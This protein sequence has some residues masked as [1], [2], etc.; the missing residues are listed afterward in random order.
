MD[1]GIFV[2]FPPPAPI[3][4]VTDPLGNGTTI[5]ANDAE[6]QFSSPSPCIPT[7]PQLQDCFCTELNQLEQ[8]YINYPPP[9][10]CSMC[11]PPP[12]NVYIANKLNITYGTSITDIDVLNYESNCE[13]T[14]TPS[15]P[16][17]NGPP[18]AMNCNTYPNS[19]CPE[20]AYTI[21]NYDAQVQ[22][23]QQK[24]Q[25]LDDFINNYMSAAFNG[26]D[27]YSE[28]MGVRYINGE[29][30]YT[31]YY[32]DL[33]GNLTRTVP[34]AGVDI[35]TDAQVSA[36]VIP[37]HSKITYYQYNTLNELVSET[38]PDAGYTSH[39][40]DYAGRLRFSQNANQVPL[41][42]YSYT[43]YDGVGRIIE[44]GE[45]HE[46]YPPSGTSPFW[47]GVND[48][49]FPAPPY[50]DQVTQTYYDIPFPWS[51]SG[52]QA[53]FDGG[54]QQNLEAR[55]ATTT[56]AS[57][58][59][60]TGAYD[61][62]THYSYDP[63][64][65]VANLLQDNPSLGIFLE[66]GTQEYKKMRYDY[67]LV[68]GNVNMVDYQP[69][70]PDQFIHKY[71]Y[72]ADNR[73]TNAYTSADSVI[74]DQDAKYFYYLHG[75]L[76]R[77]EIGQD[78]VQGE[79]Y[80]Y[81]LQGWLKGVNANVL[82]PV[83]DIGQDGIN[84]PGNYMPAPYTNAQPYIHMNIAQD[85]FGYTLNYFAG[86]NGLPG[87]YY[88][89]D[90]VAATAPNHF[91]KNHI[92]DNYDED[93]FNGNIKQT[94]AALS[95][96]TNTALPL[97]DIHYQ[98]D[99]LNRLLQS[100]PYINAVSTTDYTSSAPTN[101]SALLADFATAYTYD[102]DGNI[103]N[104]SRN[105]A[106]VG[107]TNNLDNLTYSYPANTPTPT[108]NLL[109][110]VQDNPPAGGQLAPCGDI[111]PG[112]AAGNYSY[113]MIGQLISDGSDAQIQN[114][115]W[116]IYGK[117]LSVTRIPTSILSDLQ[118]SYDP[119]GNR[120]CKIEIPKDVS[121]NPL[122]QDH[123][124]YT[125]YVRDASGN[126]M[127]IYNRTFSSPAIPPLHYLPSEQ[128]TLAENPIYGS[129]RI[130]DANRNTYV[131]TMSY[132]FGGYNNDGTII[133]SGTYIGKVYNSMSTA[134][135]SQI[136]QGPNYQ[137]QT[138]N[139]TYELNDHLGDVLMT[140]SDRKLPIVSATNP[141]NVDHYVADVLSYNTYYPFG[142]EMKGQ[143]NTLYLNGASGT[144]YRFAY[145]G[146]E[147]DHE[148]KG[149]DNSYT[150]EFREFDPRLGRWFT[151][152][153]RT[154]EL[155]W[156]SPYLS[157]G[158]NPIMLNDINGDVWKTDADEKK[159][160]K[161]DNIA[162]TLMD[163]YQNQLDKLDPKSANY[164]SDKA[165]L[166]FK[167]NEL[168][169]AKDELQAMGNDKSM[170]FQFKDTKESGSDNTS[171]KY[172][173]GYTFPD[174]TTDRLPEVTMT[175]F[176]DPDD[177][178]GN[179]GSQ[180]HEAKHAYQMLTGDLKNTYDGADKIDEVTSEVQAKQREYAIMGGT[181]GFM[182]GEGYLAITEANWVKQVM[183]N[184]GIEEGGKIP[185][186]YKTIA[187]KWLKKQKEKTP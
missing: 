133:Y 107:T 39:W 129:K 1:Y 117:V 67:D 163:K 58:G 8:E 122:T 144:A 169:D 171:I 116:S 176:N 138:G 106:T 59:N 114:I 182:M 44:T 7:S 154:D 132:N 29:Y 97:M 158:N 89:I 56:Y 61:Y 53:E 177:P 62:A 130:G 168:H 164:E 186:V 16:S 152:D 109:D 134:P 81:T 162:S 18:A 32:Y 145:N 5:S 34:P 74:W 139:K 94:A 40:Y 78:K 125:Y 140:V 45:S 91:Y 14:G 70:S 80:A 37:T 11:P 156:E 15:M 118:F 84:G 9:G 111:Q 178:I 153:P 147:Q 119:M 179:I 79:D 103:L 159:A 28:N 75:P 66:N 170:I 99:Q 166:T 142:Q 110:N 172:G 85:A 167:I 12:L 187:K 124:I 76:G 155:A 54:G 180:F 105:G 46:P 38:T 10:I 102:F 43:K 174:G 104:L 68:S 121:G 112:Q 49:E 82:N 64:G 93:L 52:L 150:T 31:L 175:V 113:D 185:R 2:A 42:E 22:Y 72:D 77:E 30:Q 137:R 120:I 35:L 141:P 26:I 3:N 51:T 83:V 88:S 146:M 21:A 65:N 86:S 69:E 25:Q 184:K 160:I 108:N 136:W 165:D 4:V 6:G 115:H 92:T 149:I 151:T 19:I 95:N 161:M 17:T 135:P 27:G 55:V 96:L 100:M 181:K 47:N 173:V 101:A 50:T 98:Y 126:I 57:V 157:M 71:E 13:L 24:Q 131:S 90:P 36:R 183:A 41:I 20:D 23:N 33:A 48:P 123:W 143:L 63:H 127:A 60:N 148:M 128:I 87:D 73:I